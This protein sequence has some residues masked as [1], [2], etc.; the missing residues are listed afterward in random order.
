[1]VNNV[2][3]VATVPWIVEHGGAA[4]SALGRGEEHG[5]RLVC[6]NATFARPGVYEVPLGIPLRVIVEDLAGG[7]EGGRRLRSLQVGGPL[8]GFL[9]ASRL[10]VAL[11]A[12]ALA[13]EGVSLGHASGARFRRHDPGPGAHAPSWRFAAAESCGSCSPC[14]IGSRRGLERR[15]AATWRA[16]AQLRARCTRRACAPSD[17]ASRRRSAV[18]CASMWTSDREG[19][20]PTLRCAL[21]A[22]EVEAEPWRWHRARRCLDG[23]PGRRRGRADAVHGRAARP[24]LVLPGVPGGRGGR[25]RSG[26]GVRDPGGAGMRVIRRIRHGGRPPAR[27]GA[28]GLRVARARVGHPR[29]TQRVGRR[30]RALD[31]APAAFGTATSVRGFDFSHPYVKLDRDLCIACARC[32]RMCERSQGTFALM[33]AVRGA[34]TVVAPGSG[35]SWAESDCVSCGAACSLPDRR[36]VRARVARPAPIE[37]TTTHHLRLLW[38]R[39][40]L[41]VGTRGDEVV[42]VTPGP[43]RSIAGT[44]A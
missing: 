38:R 19:G 9:P 23:V 35:G 24:V 7:L 41:E 6:V 20:R 29:G 39:L 14:R 34:A 4:Y 43:G 26:R 31:V 40:Q 37:R 17:R 33:L 13:A 27:P 10:D 18:S 21:I 1:M 5:Q 8:G 30:L 25:A 15:A 44:R 12:P 28:D 32:V 16:C 36:P 3:S 2:E 22:L 11:S 42:S